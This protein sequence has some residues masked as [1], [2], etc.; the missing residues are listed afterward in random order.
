MTD[1]ATYLAGWRD[2]HPPRLPTDGQFGEM[3]ERIREYEVHFGPKA[4]AAAVALAVAGRGGEK[5]RARVEKAV[6]AALLKPPPGATPGTR[7]PDRD[8]ARWAYFE[9]QRERDPTV[10]P[11]KVAMMIY[12]DAEASTDPLLGADQD[13]D[14]IKKDLER[15]RADRKLIDW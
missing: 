7:T 15:L 5:Q 11:Y 12:E 10:T 4:L 14:T 6:A 13:S 9:R 3:V 1:D 2:R 8:D